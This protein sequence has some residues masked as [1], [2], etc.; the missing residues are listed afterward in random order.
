MDFD[1]L[2]SVISFIFLEEGMMVLVCKLKTANLELSIQELL[3]D[4]LWKS[5]IHWEMWES[6][7]SRE[8]FSVPHSFPYANSF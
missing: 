2:S 3:Q 1:K 4:I 8:G 6:Q 5:E 7:G